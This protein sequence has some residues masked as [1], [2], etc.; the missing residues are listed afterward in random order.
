MAIACFRLVTFFPDLP[1]RSVPALRSCMTF[2]TFFCAVVL[3]EVFFAALFF[4]AV[5]FA[6]RFFVAVFFVAGLRALVARLFAVL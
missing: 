2:F 5:F 3:A 1:L 4:F 6:A